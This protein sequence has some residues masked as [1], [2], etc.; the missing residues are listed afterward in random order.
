MSEWAWP[1][2][3][4]AHSRMSKLAF[5]VPFSNKP[6]TTTRIWCVSRFHVN[7]NIKQTYKSGLHFTVICCMNKCIINERY[8]SR[9][10][11]QVKHLW[12]SKLRFFCDFFN[13][14]KFVKFKF[15]IYGHRPT[16]YAVNAT[17]VTETEFLLMLKNTEQCCLQYRSARSMDTAVCAASGGILPYQLPVVVTVCRVATAPKHT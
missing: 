4:I 10:S 3:G 2:S 15:S 12:L 17:L 6:T 1:S 9:T 5:S 13:W 8:N 16:N 14:K 11:K 7:K